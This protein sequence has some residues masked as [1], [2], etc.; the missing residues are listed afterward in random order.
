MNWFWPA[1]GL[2][3]GLV[4]LVYALDKWKARRGRWRT[5]EATLLWLAAVGGGLGATLAIFLIRHKSR[6]PLFAFGV[7][8]MLAAQ[9]ALYFWVV[10]LPGG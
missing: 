2:Y 9:A 4:F 1:F 5:P 7:P 6:K 8:L 3:N 10:G